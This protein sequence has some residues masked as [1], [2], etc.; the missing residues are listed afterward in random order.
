MKT[1]R[2]IYYFKDRA[3]AAAWATENGWPVDR[4]IEYGRGWAI[5]AGKSGNYAGPGESPRP[6]RGYANFLAEKEKGR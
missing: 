5:Q 1:Y 4:I 3:S 2:G 6:W